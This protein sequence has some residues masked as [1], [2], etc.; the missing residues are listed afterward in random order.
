MGFFVFTKANHLDTKFFF[1]WNLHLIKIKASVAILE[2]KICFWKVQYLG[3]CRT[4]KTLVNQLFFAFFQQ[5]L[6]ISSNQTKKL[7][8]SMYCTVWERWQNFQNRQTSGEVNK[9]FLPTLSIYI[10]SIFSKMSLKGTVAR[11]F[12]VSVFFMDLLYMGP[13]FRG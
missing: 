7:D 11:D 4:V 6:A 8:L 5:R 10:I 12:L 2:P 3:S 9:L 13:R 1:R